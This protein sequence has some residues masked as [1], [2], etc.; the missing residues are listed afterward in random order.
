M[1]HNE[2]R[3]NLRGLTS[4]LTLAGFL[5][6]S[7]TGLVLYMVPHGRIAYWTNWTF[8]LLTKT[9]WGDIHIL[10]SI[11][12]IIAGG[13]HTYFNWKP[14]MNYLRDRSRGGVKLKKEIA[15]SVAAMVII[16]LSGIYKLPPLSYLIHLNETIKAAWV[17]SKE[18]EP[19]FGHAEL[20]SLRV[21]CKKTGL[22]LKES[23]AELR[24]RG[25]E[26]V[27]PDRT[28]EQIAVAN[29][30]SPLD[31]YRM[32]KKLEVQQ[33]KGVPSQPPRTYTTRLVEE[34]FAGTGLGNLS[35]SDIGKKV[36]VD[37]PKLLTRLRDKGVEGSASES[38]KTM[39]TRNGLAPLEVLKAALV[40]GYAPQKR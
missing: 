8:L 19:P 32:I 15:I 22:P 23:Q 25:L 35:L 17:V 34:T 20:L 30:I 9:N 36:G 13:F 28:V 38:L 16:T 29:R 37:G 12:F 1:E 33:P 18:Y 4:L 24:R 11:L 40:E 3:W 26:G 21:F 2:N 14:L 39:A 6:M 7:V 10:S 5:I 27:G 31:V